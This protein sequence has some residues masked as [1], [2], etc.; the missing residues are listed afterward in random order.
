MI[1]KVTKLMQSY[2]D[3]SNTQ[4]WSSEFHKQAF[5]TSK[6]G[7]EYIYIKPYFLGYGTQP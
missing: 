6:V 7:N 4:L 2:Q 5:N 1:Q 3:G